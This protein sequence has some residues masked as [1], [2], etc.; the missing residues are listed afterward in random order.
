MKK[1]L[2]I[3][4]THGLN[5]E[6]VKDVIKQ[7]QPDICVHCGDYVYDRQTMDELFTYYVN[8]NN[9]TAFDHEHDA[10]NFEIEGIKF[11]VIHGHQF[12]RFNHHVWE[13]SLHR[14][15]KNNGADVLL[16]GH[17]HRYFVKS[18]GDQL[19]LANPGS[20]ALP[21]NGTPTYM[22][23]EVNNHQIEFLKRICQKD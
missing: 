2:V 22:V 4:D 10:V 14:Y 6:R 7:E 3:S 21:Y 8:G 15:L 23:I 9:D 11:A 5:I 17:S 19:V 18:F 12:P 13:N 16:H 20:I 1:I